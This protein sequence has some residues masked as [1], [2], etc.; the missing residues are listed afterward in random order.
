[1]KKWKIFSA[2]IV[3]MLAFGWYMVAVEQV[4]ILSK[5]DLSLSKVLQ[6]P[7]I[8]LKTRVD[9][10]E[11]GSMD[12][13]CYDAQGNL[14]WEELDRPNDLADEGEYLF[15]DVTLRGA[16]APANYYLRLFNDTPAE[17]D[18]LG[19]LT[20]EPT[21]N[22]YTAQT[23]EGSGTG[24]PTLALDSGDYQATSSTETFTAS[25]GSWGPVTYCV[26]ATST[27]GSGKLV[28]YVALSTSRT[29]ASGESLQVTYKLKLQ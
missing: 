28:S 7:H 24:W 9:V 25:G 5:W 8:N 2:L 10:R 3:L 11:I 20:G 21:E 14:K 19:S 23:V 16:S 6:S 4:P 27:D 29:L 13:R 15:L 18:T 17:T 1:M 12:F 26:L 22:G